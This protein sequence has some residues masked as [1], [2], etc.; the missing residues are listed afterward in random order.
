MP[1]AASPPLSPTFTDLRR[2]RPFMQLWVARL[3]GT[4]ASQMMLVA[5]GWHMYELTS[6]NAGTNW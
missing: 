3:F 1:G 5:I 2:E 6:S 4:A